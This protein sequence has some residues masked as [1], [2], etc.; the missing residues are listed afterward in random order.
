VSGLARVLAGLAGVAV[1]AG[2]AAAWGHLRWS[3]LTDAR[4]ALLQAAR[5]PAPAAPV[6]LASTRDLPAPVRRYLR[7]VLSDGAPRIAALRIAHRGTFD[8]AGRGDD[9]KPFSS[10][11]WIVTMRPGFVWDARIAM[12]PGVAVR[13]HDAYLAGEGVLQASVL[14]LVDVAH[15]RGGD[16]IARGELMRWLAETAWYPTALLP[17]GAVSWEPVDDR[18]ARAT[19]VDGPVSATLTVRFGDDD[20]IA[21]VRA[22]A[23]G[24]AVGDR[25][26]QAPWEGRFGDYASR[27]GMLVPTTGEVAWDLPGG[28]LPY[29]RGTIERFEPEFARQR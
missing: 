2:E 14:G 7:K 1:V 5:V 11:Q 3:R 21:G 24:R 9:W 26:E 17:G 4:V 29:W 13:V 25:I 28:R 8:A 27:A 15:L 10:R 20:L 23:R 12:A 22:E 18:S 6:D 16:E 19:V